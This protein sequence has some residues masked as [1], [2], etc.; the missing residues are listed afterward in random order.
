[1]PFSIC[2]RLHGQSDT[3]VCIVKGADV[4]QLLVEK[5]NQGGVKNITVVHPTT[6]PELAT[7]LANSRVR[8][9]RGMDFGLLGL[10][11]CDLSLG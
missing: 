8:E 3:K 1:M 5:Q 11:P 4:G 2:V 9:D 7:R 10:Y 6:H